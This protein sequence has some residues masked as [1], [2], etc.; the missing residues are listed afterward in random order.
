MKS[1]YIKRLALV[2]GPLFFVLILSF[3]H[4]EGLSKAANAVLASTAWIA[5]WWVFEVVPIAVTA[6]LP[7][8][9]FPLTGA[10]PLSTTTAA[11]GH[12]YVFLYIGGF[13]LAIAIEKWNL[14]K[15]I[16]LNVINLIGT[17]VKN[18]ILGFMVATA[19]LS[20]WISNT[21]TAV[22]MLPIGMAI[23]TQL[24]DNPDTIE[25]ENTI[26][27]KAL[28]LAIAYS[29]S[30]GGVATLIGTPPN[31]IFAG[32][33]EEQYHIEMT[34]SKWIIF[35]LPIA[36]ILLI[37][38]WL[39]LTKIAFRFKQSEFPGGKTE[40]KRQLNALG[41]ISYE[42]KVVLIIFV[43]TAFLWITR[44]FLLKDLIPGIDDTIIAMISATV[45]FLIPSKDKTSSTII[46]WKSAVKLPWGILLL[47]GG[48]LAI[49][50][51]FKVSGLANWIGLQT[52][53]IEH[54]SLFILLLVLVAAVNFLTE[55]TSNLATTAM[56]LPIIAPIALAIDVHPFTLMVGI[57]VAASCAF[58]LPVATPPNAIVFGSGYL[59]IP[60][61]V[62]SGI[63]LNIISIV[64]IA[65]TT[66]FLLPL[67]WT[68]DPAIFP[69]ALK[70]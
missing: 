26:F 15:R 46:D 43:S 31:L 11:F 36:I 69:E 47:F 40:I 41:N 45:L 52:T 19:F 66:Y 60:D 51:G 23:I 21:A 54:L 7:I 13:T 42:E 38:C 58:M 63:W 1:Q 20:M 61:M 25:N 68:F 4:P 35:G 27:G 6:M 59:K 2:L 37:I 17:S 8:I 29:A 9:L 22:M 56:L 50:E 49:A 33:L 39:Y 30:I 16:A 14:H 70:P 55:I 48:G 62:R 64:L 44:S 65:V 3:F 34:F 53:L 24:K 12:K 10:M 57:T 5:T 28:M 67:L 32:I 18:I